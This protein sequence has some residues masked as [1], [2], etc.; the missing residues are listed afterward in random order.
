MGKHSHAHGRWP[1]TWLVNCDVCGFTYSSDQ[2]RK[3]WDGLIVCPEDFELDHPQKY[4]RV[5][6]DRIAPLFVRS[7]P[8]DQFVLVCTMITNQGVAGAG[9]AGCMVAGRDNNLPNQSI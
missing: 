5:Q 7:E 2:V 9:V 4:I 6:G 3:R 8:E 1:G